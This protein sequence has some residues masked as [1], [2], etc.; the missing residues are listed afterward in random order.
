MTAYLLHRTPD[1]NMHLFADGALTTDVLSGTC[2]KVE[3][4][5]GSNFAWIVAGTTGFRDLFATTLVDNNVID[6]DDLIA[7]VAELVR[8]VNDKLRQESAGP[9]FFEFQLCIVGWSRAEGRVKAY[10]YENSPFSDGPK[11]Q[12]DPAENYMSPGPRSLESGAMNFDWPSAT[13]AGDALCSWG[14][15]AME[16]MRKVRAGVYRRT[17]DQYYVI[18]GHVQHVVIA[19]DKITS[20]VIHVWSD[21]LGQP[22]DGDAV[23]RAVGGAPAITH[24]V[25]LSSVA[26]SA[27]AMSAS[28]LGL[29]LGRMGLTC[30]LGGVRRG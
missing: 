9:S 23:G 4:H 14:I 24:S 25:C 11:F 20:E 28:P 3:L 26:A 5:S 16:A 18:G 7:S 19:P 17:D 22:I 29:G 8:V 27:K 12:L 30:C 10:T 2:L 1:G 15:T 6:F 21:S 13:L